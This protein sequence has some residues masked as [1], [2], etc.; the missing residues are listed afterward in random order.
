M[1]ER[2]VQQYFDSGTRSEDVNVAANMYFVTRMLRKPLAA[3]NF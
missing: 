3:V 1:L 2:I